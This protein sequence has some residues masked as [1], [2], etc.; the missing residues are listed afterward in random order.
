M[1]YLDLTLPD[2]EA[3]LA[4][5]EAL[6]D[7]CDEGEN[8]DVLRFWEAPRPFVVVGYANP[9]A[10]EA[11]LAVCQDRKIPLL[12]RCSG[13]GTVVQGPGCLNYSLILR[14]D[15]EPALATIPATNRFV[16]EKHRQIFQNLLQ[17]EVRVRGHTDLAVGERKFS[18]NAQ[19]RKRRAVLFHGTVLLGFDLSL[20]E[21]LLPMPSKQPLYRANRSHTAFLINL[22]IP[23]DRVKTALREAWQA[24][25]PLESWPSRSTARLV[26]EKYSTAEWNLRF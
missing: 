17:A 19:R 26:Q 3:N 16:M 5:D 18:G 10:K 9:V 12:R 6:L 21:E 11:N 1:K 24:A 8:G 13:G 15:Q 4:C 20:V 22:E 7:G 25:E 2:P 23:A 14:S